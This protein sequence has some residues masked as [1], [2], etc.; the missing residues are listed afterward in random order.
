[1]FSLVSQQSFF[2]PQALFPTTRSL[3]VVEAVVS[4]LE[5]FMVAGFAPPTSGAG[6]CTPG[7]MLAYPVP[8]QAVR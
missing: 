8:S 4:G 1:M 6:L 3:A 2:L 7:D 5:V